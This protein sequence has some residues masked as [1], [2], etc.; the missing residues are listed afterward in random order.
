MKKALVLVCTLFIVNAVFGQA[1]IITYIKG[2]VYHDHKL[3]KLHDKLDGV[4]QITSNDK[5][6]ELALF[7][8]QKG[9]FRLSFVNCKAVAD[10]K[11]TNNSELYQL[12]VANYLL[13]Y[14]TEKTLT[15]RGENF[16]LQTFFSTTDTGRNGN[17]IF[18]LEDELLPIRSLALNNQPQDKFFICTV[19]G[20]DTTC[21]PIIR[22]NSF[23]IFDGQALKD[24]FNADSQEP[25]LV[26]CFIKRG[27][28]INNKYAEE[29][30]S[31]PVNI[32]FLSKRYLQSVV[33][34]FSEGLES[35]YNN[36]KEKLIAD[37]EE[38]LAYYHGHYFE[39]AVHQ[40]LKSYLK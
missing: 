12:I 23:L 32:N 11:T 13:T 10:N 28:A 3:L 27:H 18:L 4:T 30:F 7:S 19:K 22:N 39:P 6:A 9:K 24:I 33:G 16:D 21:C 34:S 37:V 35:Y 26:T 5:T 31:G 25:Q 14:T 36:N 15:A 20:K 38:Q 29:Y 2:D 17:T 40:V 1:Y 8:A